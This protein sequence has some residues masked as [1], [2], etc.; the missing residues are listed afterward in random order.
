MSSLRK[1]GLALVGIL[2]GPV[3]GDVIVQEGS[4]EGDA[5]PPTEHLI[6]LDRFDTRDG[7]RVLDAV[8]LEFHTL[9]VAEAVTNG[10][11]GFVEV[12]A[13]LTADYGHPGQQAFAETE[14]M[15]F[16]VLDNGD[17]PF[18]ILYL[19]EDLAE[20]VLDD[21]GEIAP[22]IGEGTIE[23]VGVAQL[24]LEEDPADVIDFFGGGQVGYTVTY[25]F[26]V[27]EACPT[28]LDGDGTTDGGDLGIFFAEWGRCGD[29]RADFDGSGFIDG[30][31]LGMPF[32]AWG[33]CS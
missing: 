16:D 9:L 27:P 6:V 28:D 19:D 22:W 32:V 2:A 25:D 1:P 12:E 4:L 7:T 11:G 33:P 13:R 21:A 8:T 3:L 18:A 30:V 29:C 23:L 17:D 31:D 20:V 15:I 26:H 5:G 24:V 10:S 14:A